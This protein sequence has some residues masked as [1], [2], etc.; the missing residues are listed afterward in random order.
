V[1]IMVECAQADLHDVCRE[2]GMRALRAALSSRAPGPDSFCPAGGVGAAGVAVSAE[3]LRAALAQA[4]PSLRGLAIS[5]PR[6]DWQD[7]G[8][9]AA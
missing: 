3:D 6:K 9:G 8:R 7:A 4:H 1:I 2:A 5:H